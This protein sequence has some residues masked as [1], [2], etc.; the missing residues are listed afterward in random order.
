MKLKLSAEGEVAIL[1]VLE[2]VTLE[3]ITVLRA[4]ITKLLNSGRQKIVLNL[5]E[6]KKL[7]VETVS[8]VLKLHQGAPE[9]QN[10]V[11]LVGQGEL[12]KQALKSL[13][14]PTPVKYFSTRE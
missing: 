4:G 12:V 14:P 2:E 5:A 8:E 7:S 13:Q 10:K 9:L 11:V 3:N 6:A 1:D